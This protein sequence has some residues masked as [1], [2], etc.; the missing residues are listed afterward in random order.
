MNNKPILCGLILLII[1]N[2]T[3]DCS[4]SQQAAQK[5]A[6]TS[7]AILAPHWEKD[8]Q[9]AKGEGNVIVY[10]TANPSTKQA[11]S[12]VM[13]DRYGI[14]VDFLGGRGEELI[15]R[16]MTE[17]RA[18]LYLGDV[19]LMG[20]GGPVLRTTLKP[21]GAVANLDSTLI[22]P[23][24]T[25]PSRWRGGK[26]PF[27]DKEHQI[28][29]FVSQTGGIVMV[30]TESGNPKDTKSYHD[31]LNPRWKGKII[32][33][34]PTVIGAGRFWANLMLMLF[35]PQKGK[36]YL[37]QIAKQDLIVLRDKRLVVDWVARNKYPMAIGAD[38]QTYSEFR[39]NGAPISALQFNEGS[40]GTA[41]G[42][43]IA[44]LKRAAHPNAAKVFINWLLTMEGQ[45]IFQKAAGA[46]SAR[47]DVDMAGIDPGFI[48]QEGKRLIPST[49][50]E[51]YA[52]EATNGE[53]IKRIFQPLMHE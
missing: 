38:A 27:L 26:L 20:M 22:L 9:A 23:E 8:L 15:Q 18:G 51:W 37:Q 50:E 46:P 41:S 6:Q 17:N 10:T 3:P 14:T 2:I 31:L 39:A 4:A 29:G 21:I 32:M 16:I 49:G 19:L 1:F 28:I 34:D 25:D 45:T 24:V 43:C 30:N 42:G 36:D 47:L 13:Q 52:S 11:I 5:A 12:K 40:G 48:P 53:I 7:K 35:G 33:D 44:M